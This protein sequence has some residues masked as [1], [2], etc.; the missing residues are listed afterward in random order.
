MKCWPQMKVHEA[1]VFYPE[2]SM[3]IPLV[4]HDRPIIGESLKIKRRTFKI[5]DIVHRTDVGSYRCFEVIV[6]SAMLPDSKMLE[7]EGWSSYTP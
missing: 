1:Q 3:F 5:R 6:G 7:K 4:L 2:I